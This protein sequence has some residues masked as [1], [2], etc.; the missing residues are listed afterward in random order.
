MRRL[1]ERFRRIA[2][3]RAVDAESH[4][5]CVLAACT[6]GRRALVVCLNCPSAEARRLRS[7]GMFEGASV[8]V[9]G[10]RNGMLLEV[11]GARVAVDGLIAM[12]VTV[13]PL[14]S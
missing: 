12:S 4:E 3:A 2:N 5:P 10:T 8:A 9:V 14:G 1:L 11:Q 7:L 6:P 13:L